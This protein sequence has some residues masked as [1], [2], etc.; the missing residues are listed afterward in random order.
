MSD[1]FPKKYDN[2]IENEIYKYWLSK[3][4]FN[5]DTVEKIRNE[6][7]KRSKWN[8][9]ISLPPPNV[10]W[11]LHTWHSLTISIEDIL[12]RYNRMKWKKTLW[13]PWTD[14]A[15]IATQL[16]VE[17][18][19]NKKWINRK[20]LGR[21]EFLSK[22]WEWV[23][24]SRNTIVSQTKKMWASCD[25]SREQFTLSEKL[26]RA[27]RKSFSNLYKEWKIYKSSYLINWCPTSQTVLSDLEVNYKEEKWKLYYIK[28]FIEWKWESITIATT[29]PETIFAD[30]A[31][32][33]NPIDRR[34]KR[35]IGKK[36]LIPIVNRMIEVIADE[37]VDISFGTWALKITP[38]HDINDFE[39]WKRHNLPMDKYAIDKQWNFTELAWEFAWKNV[40]E[41]YDNLIHNLREIWNLWKTEDHIH[42]VPYSDRANTKIQSMVSEQWF[43]NVDEAAQKSTDYIKNNEI[44]VYPERFKKTFFDWME[45][46]KPWCISR[47]LRWWHRIP[48]WYCEDWHINT[49]DED[50]VLTEKDKNKILS[51]I[52]FN[53]IADSHLK[54]TF[55]LQELINVL[56]S[57]SLTPQNWKLYEVYCDIYRTK[58]KKDKEKQQEIK[59]IIKVF[60][61]ISKN[62]N[63]IIKNWWLLVDILDNSSN[64]INDWELY[65]FKFVC[66]HCQKIWLNQEEDVLDTWFSSW[67]WPFSI[68]WWPEKTKDLEEYYPNSVMETG[69]DIIFFRVAR[70]TMMWAENMNLKPFDNIYLHGLVRDENWQK[71]S[72]SKWNNID[73]MK[74]IEK[75]WADS[76]RLSLVIWTTPWNDTKFSKNKVEYNRRFI[77]K[78]WNASRFIYMKVLD[79]NNNIKLNYDL[80]KE[81]I[82]N[83]IDKL[84]KFDK[85]IINKTNDL[86]SSSEK[87]MNKFMLGEFGGK[88]I[89]TV[90][91]DFCDWYIEISKIEKS[92]YTEKTLIYTLGTLLKLVHL[93]I[94]FITEKLWQ[95]LNFEWDLIVQDWPNTIEFNTDEFRVNVL[96]DLISE[97]R[98]LKQK[99][100][101]KPHEKIKIFIKWNISILE[102][103]KENEEFMNKLLKIEE[104]KYLQENQEIEDGYETWLLLDI[105]IWLKVIKEINNKERLKELEDKL[106]EEKQF[107]QNLRS[108]IT[109]PWFVDNAPKKVVDE[110]RKK[111]DE[112]KKKIFTLNLEI[113][114]I[115]IKIK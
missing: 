3:D 2:N 32:A 110:K 4:L 37:Y 58:F 100:W 114:K 25:W 80:L 108:F 60:D 104:I 79:W 61:S 1:I 112:V 11:I 76:L 9:S 10:T 18:E 43:V 88:I 82:E 48:V 73:P 103:L 14:H 107:L 66:Q 64:I 68:L 67:L 59:D 86:I 115:K 85:W 22:V 94:P 35:H 42:T 49:F 84:N 71:M 62:S 57:N 19:I 40:D 34:Y 6:N 55:S 98:W 50:N 95:L 44:N 113:D 102:Y 75:Y 29:R 89:N 109:N 51:I 105:Q 12:I 72:K 92:E 53:L 17:R 7:W 26:S 23:K 27:V 46:I 74:Y 81:D 87:N 5:P 16:V 41:F 90:W 106:E 15:W 36:V 31:I 52:I 93:Y 21:E 39:I 54:E 47:Q 30:V 24:K 33:V 45:K 101:V 96:M 99:S 91:H 38:T 13:V 69:Y 83:N 20:D 77:N 56:L 97:F 28:Y 78:L 63:N 111:I 8:F 70:M 65:K